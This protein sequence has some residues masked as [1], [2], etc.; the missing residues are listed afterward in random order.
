MWRPLNEEDTWPKF[1]LKAI[2]RNSHTGKR[3][4]GVAPKGREKIL[5]HFLL[6]K[7]QHQC[8]CI[9]LLR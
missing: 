5:N 2:V 8:Y 3:E 6:P 1:L 4:G 9:H 7:V